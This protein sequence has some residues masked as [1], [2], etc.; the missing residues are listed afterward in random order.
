[1]RTNVTKLV[2]LIKQDD[3]D[4]STKYRDVID[5]RRQKYWLSAKRVMDVWRAYVHQSINSGQVI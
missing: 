5:M 2:K 4:A 1:M 3:S